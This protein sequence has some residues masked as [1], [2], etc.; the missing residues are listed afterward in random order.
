MFFVRALGVGHPGDDL[1]STPRTL[2]VVPPGP[3]V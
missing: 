3:V 1:L 2:L